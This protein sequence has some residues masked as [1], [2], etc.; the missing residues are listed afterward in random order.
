MPLIAM[1]VN[2]DETG[3]IVSVAYWTVG[4][5]DDPECTPE[6]PPMGRESVQHAFWE[7]PWKRRHKT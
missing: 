4:G 1:R 6:S 3:Q 2:E 7:W 5:P